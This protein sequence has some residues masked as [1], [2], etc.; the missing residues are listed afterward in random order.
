MVSMSLL[1]TTRSLCP[2]CHKIIDASMVE[3][4]GKVWLEKSC[5]EHGA[6]RELYWSD[7]EMY[8][9]ADTYPFTGKGIRNP[10]INIAPGKVVC[11]YN[12][13]ICTAHKSQTILANVF[14]TNRCNKRCWY[15]FAGL[16]TIKKNGFVYEPSFEQVR[17]ML[18]TL[19]DQKPV[20]VDAVQFTGGEPTM[21]EDMLEIV[22]E[23]VKMGF[24]YR[25]LN[26]NGIAFALDSELPKKY[27]QAG[28]NVVYMS[29]D[30]VTEK[31][32]PKNHKYILAILENCRKA[33][34]PITLVP[35]LINGVNDHE[36]WDIVK[37]AFDNNDIIR[38]VNFQP[39]SFVGTMANEVF[40]KEKRLNQRVTIPDLLKKLEE[41]SSGKI[42]AKCFYPI[43]SVKPLSEIISKI[44][45]GVPVP[46]FSCGAHCGAAT[47]IFKDGDRLV[48]ISEF[49]NIDAF[50]QLMREIAN[51]EIN[52]SMGKVKATSKLYKKLGGVIKKDKM[53][54]NFDISKIIVDILTKRTN[55][56]DKFHWTALMIGVMHFMDPYN[57]DV[58]R[59]QRC[60]IHYATPD[61]RIIPFC[62]FNALPE[63]YRD[64]INKKFGIPIAEWEKQTGK[65]LEDDL[66]RV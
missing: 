55:A 35:T 59:V 57:Y 52:T 2:K 26:T 12:C 6:W 37:F 3:D 34:L 66:K 31:T 10:A 65:K 36:I 45:G 48:P 56:I 50:F 22:Q 28:I 42:P 29:F 58:D 60:V 41:Q 24:G 49:I 19:R 27:K 63:I 61:G 40:E 4:G 46:E 11:P 51:E 64:K 18:Q 14:V 1:K 30:G 38:S 20:P 23:A 32:N 54:K 62:A 17:K 13:G 53:P 5:K 9:R 43:S 15:C 16:D 47:Y 7:A 21:R 25:L 39:V 33:N 8:K 44:R